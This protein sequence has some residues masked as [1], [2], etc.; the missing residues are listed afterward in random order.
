MP[1][2]FPRS[3]FVRSQSASVVIIPWKAQ[4]LPRTCGGSRVCFLLPQPEPWRYTHCR[5]RS[6]TVDLGRPAAAAG[7]V[8]EVSGI[9][10]AWEV[11]TDPVSSELLPWWLERLLPLDLDIWRYSRH[12]GS[13]LPWNGHF[14]AAWCCMSF[15]LWMIS[16]DGK[17]NL[18]IGPGQNVTGRTGNNVP[19]SRNIGKG[20]TK[21]NTCLW[22]SLN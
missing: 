5:A 4:A 2:P 16:S 6:P 18:E 12:R 3:D 9:S 17:K 11:K 10:D 22:R 1:F 14:P 7:Q 13:N 20:V 8:R 15:D 19:L 21:G